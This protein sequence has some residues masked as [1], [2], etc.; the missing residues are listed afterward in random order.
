MI[1]AASER[2]E[3][4]AV[5]SASAVNYNSPL[6]RAFPVRGFAYCLNEALERRSGLARNSSH[7]GPHQRCGSRRATREDQVRI[8]KPA[9]SSRDGSVENHHHSDASKQDWYD[10][11]SA[12]IDSDLYTSLRTLAVGGHENVAASC[13]PRDASGVG[14]ADA[15]GLHRTPYRVEEPV[16][17][18]IGELTREVKVSSDAQGAAHDLVENR[19]LA[20]I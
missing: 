11:F 18:F 14:I 13:G 2:S 5:R 6:A 15:M 16:G 4:A 12:A 7:C 10:Q 1:V 19:R 17:A 9:V 8:G 3:P 20:F